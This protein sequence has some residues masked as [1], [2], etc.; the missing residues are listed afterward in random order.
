[1]QSNEVGAPRNAALEAALARTAS[2]PPPTRIGERRLPEADNYDD[3]QYVDAP[4][5]DYQDN[6]PEDD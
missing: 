1:M 4:Y 3:F 6:E 2:L 5:D